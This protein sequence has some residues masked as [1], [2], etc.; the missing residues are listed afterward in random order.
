MQ[1]DSDVFQEPLGEIDERDPKGSNT[2]GE[3]G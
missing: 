1:S 3:L 2:G